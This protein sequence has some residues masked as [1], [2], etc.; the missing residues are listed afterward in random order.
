MFNRTDQIASVETLSLRLL[1]S[2][3]VAAALSPAAHAQIHLPPQSYPQQSGWPA[4]QQPGYAM[5]QPGYAP[6][7]PGFSGGQPSPP[8]GLD[9]LMAWERQDMGVAPIKTLRSGPMHGAT[10][11]QIPGGQVITTKGLVELMQNPRGVNVLVLDAL[12]TPQQLPGAISAVAASQSG[13]FNDPTQQQLGQWL[14]QMTRGRKDTP[15]VFYC[16]G[17]Q[18]WMSYNAALR[19]IN[20]GYQ[21][22]LWYR[23][24]LDAWQRAGL[25]LMNA[26]QA[27]PQQVPAGAYQGAPADAYP[28]AQPGAYPGLSGRFTF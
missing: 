12:G 2:F 18:C 22:V 14:Q 19:A 21:N 4:Q 6:A 23:G 28:G 10:P 7:P 3:L 26:Q 1:A 13:S 11:N 17:P 25:P 16:Q 24:G 27:M 8:T 5:P 9:E 20:L 15:L